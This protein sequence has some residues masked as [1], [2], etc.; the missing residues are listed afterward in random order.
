MT[1]VGTYRDSEPVTAP[2]AYPGLTP[3]L[4]ALA[5][6]A[7]LRNYSAQQKAACAVYMRREE[8]ID[9]SDYRTGDSVN[10]DLTY[11][12]RVDHHASKGQGS[13]RNPNGGRT[14]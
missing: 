14:R 6:Y 12:N 9:V 5:T 2:T 13:W 7:G 1:P 10:D 3:F 4:R 8:A 11:E